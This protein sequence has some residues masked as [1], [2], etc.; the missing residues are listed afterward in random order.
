VAEYEALVNSLCIAAELGVLWLYIRGDSK[1][2]I[3]QVMGES[4]YRDSHKATYRQEVR[5]LEEKFDGFELHHILRRD[6]KAA[7]ALAQLRSSCEPPPPGIFTHDLFKPSIRLE[8]NI[9]VPKLGISSNEDSPV[10]APE[11]P[12]RKDGPVLPF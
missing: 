9:L 1:L 12:L 11:S 2:I 4:N 6:N 5:K 10:P 8:E 3:N 7:D